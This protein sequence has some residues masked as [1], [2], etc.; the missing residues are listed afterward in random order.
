MKRRNFILLSSVASSVVLTGCMPMLLA[1]GMGGMGMDFTSAT[2]SNPLSSSANDKT[3][4]KALAIPPL[5]EGENRNGTY[6]YDLKIQKAQHEFFDNTLTDT[7]AVNGTYLAPTLKL[8]NGQ[9]VSLNYTNKLDETTT[10]HGHGM[11][12]PAKMDGTAHQSIAPDARW[13]AKYRVKQKA[14]TNW[15]HPHAHEK[16]AEHVYKGLAGLII[17]ED[18]QS[19]SLDL[20]KDYGVDDIPLVLQDR[21]FDAKGQLHYAPSMHQTMMGYKG[22]AFVTNGVIN[23]YVEVS[24]KE[25]RLRLLNGSNSTVYNLSFSDNRSFK[26]IATDNSFLESPV[27]LNSVLLSPGERAEIVVNLEDDLGGS[28][29]LMETRQAKA[30]LKINVNTKATHRTKVPSVLTRLDKGLVQDATHRRKFVLSARMG[31]MYINNKS[32][33][34]NRVNEVIPLNRVE[35]WE[36]HNQKMMMMGMEHNF[37]MHGTHFMVVERNGSIHNVLEN[38]KGYKDTVYLASGDSVKLV[39][40]MTDYT[41]KTTPYMYHCHF[42]EHEDRGMMGQFL[43]TK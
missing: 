37:H 41:D 6:H 31:Q 11:H 32:M 23:P 21:F 14:C 38:E 19:Q 2:N 5:L 10:M 28:L 18:E 43:V 8:I 29:Y 34:M 20:P 30:F 26:Q 24:A 33:D 1:G 4:N 3:F 12:L 15:Y 36:V 22:D 27:V 9:D 35:I 42:L 25:I 40:K 16:T 7:Y 17:I 39:V 13:S